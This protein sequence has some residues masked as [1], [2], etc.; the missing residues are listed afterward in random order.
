MAVGGVTWAETVK[1]E[2]AGEALL[3][4]YCGSPLT[5]VC[6]MRE[7]GAS[8]CG[9]LLFALAPVRAVEAGMAA[10]QMPLLLLLLLME[11]LSG[12][13]MPGEGQGRYKS[14]WRWKGDRTRE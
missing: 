5:A 9:P 14:S 4:F 10:R 1:E 12:A 13:C 2:E 8:L 6:D 7:P 11:V 3:L